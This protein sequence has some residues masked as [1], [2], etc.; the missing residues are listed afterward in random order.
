MDKKGEKAL[1]YGFPLQR[2]IFERGKTTKHA[3]E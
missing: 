3:N 1:N 2:I